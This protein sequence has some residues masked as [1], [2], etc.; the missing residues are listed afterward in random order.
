PEP[1]AVIVRRVREFDASLLQELFAE[2]GATTISPNPAFFEDEKNILL[3]AYDSNRPSG[4]LYGY[5]LTS[6]RVKSPKLFLYSI[7]VATQY[8]HRGVGT[9]L[10]EELKS[11]A[12]CESCSEIFVL[13]NKSNS[14]AIK[15]YER[16]GGTP[17]NEDDVMFVYS[18][19]AEV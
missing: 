8:Q 1:M 7:D 9:L 15:L 3:V 19:E 12:R 16:T 18:G 6:L 14:A 11:L 5:L 17:E 10:I 13:T 2:A 4:F